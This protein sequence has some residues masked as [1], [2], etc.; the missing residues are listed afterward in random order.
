MRYL[1]L[2]ACLAALAGAF[3]WVHRHPPGEQFI[4]TWEQ[5]DAPDN[6]WHVVNVGNDVYEV[7]DNRGRQYRAIMDRGQLRVTNGP[8]MSMTYI[9]D[10]DQVLIGTSFF[11]R[12]SKQPS[13]STHHP[14]AKQMLFAGGKRRNARQA[15]G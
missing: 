8:A 10:K 11:R 3:L 2:C 4:G 6:Q 13:V 7:R 15:H 9:A 14:S 12:V 1:V 5:V